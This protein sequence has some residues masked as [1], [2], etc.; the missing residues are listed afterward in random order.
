MQGLLITFEGGEGVGKTTQI[1]FLAKRLKELGLS[2]QTTREPGAGLL[3]QKLRAFLLHE[4]IDAKTELL[5]Y[6]A[7]RAQH[8]SDE[9]RPWLLTKQI[10]LCDRF[11]DSCEIYQGYARGL[12]VEFVR[13]L[14]HW[15]LPDLWPDLTL[16]LDMPV[17]NSL[18]RVTDRTALADRWESEN[19][20]FH[21]KLRTG[22]LE[23]AR[24][25]PTRIRIINAS[26]SLDKTAS[27]IWRQVEPLVRK[28]QG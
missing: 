27:D 28:W 21:E 17:I 20:S 26:N 10:V 7:D 4:P 11:I 14:H 2:V 1:S 18:Q 13:K 6:L 15:L 24:R 22:F 25:E 12:E 8:I 23:Q 3:G 5:L 16:L 9:L 19:L